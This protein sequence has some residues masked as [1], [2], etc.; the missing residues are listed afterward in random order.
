MCYFCEMRLIVSHFLILIL[1]VYGCKDRIEGDTIAEFELRSNVVKEGTELG[2]VQKSVNT[3]IYSWTIDGLG[4]SSSSPT[5][6]FSM[7]SAGSYTLKLV[8]K[9]GNGKTSV[10]SQTFDVL[11][12][13]IWRL[14]SNDE[15]QWSLSSF[16]LNGTEQITDVC[17]EDDIFE[18]NFSQG[19]NDS[20]FYTHETDTCSN[21]KYAYDMPAK[22]VWEF[23]SSKET[24][25]ISLMV[26]G[27]LTPFKFEIEVLTK[28]YLKAS[29]KSNNSSIIM[30]RK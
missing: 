18:L 23:D 13:T 24:F 7:D 12:D 14:S 19:T 17:Q 2:I 8:T 20:F 27:T 16:I 25:N 1:V 30:T 22:G 4:L 9:G 26:S 28:D 10:Q 29:D 15:K 21:G 6:S 3:S 11:P 5:P